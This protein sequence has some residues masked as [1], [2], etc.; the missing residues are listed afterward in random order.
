MMVS[1]IR[2][3]GPEK[4]YFKD[5]LNDFGNLVGEYTL[6]YRSEPIYEYST[7]ARGGGRKGITLD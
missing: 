1:R 4:G 5:I 2:G 7:P 3:Y 6:T